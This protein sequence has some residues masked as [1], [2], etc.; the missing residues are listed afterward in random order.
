M[1]VFMGKVSREQA[2]EAIQT[3]MKNGYT[4]HYQEK[5][6]LMR[7]C[8]RDDRLR[9]RSLTM[10]ELSFLSILSTMKEV[11]GC[12]RMRKDVIDIVKKER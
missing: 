5:K 1:E 8:Y 12:E 3:G 2:I 6:G 9:S 7:I 4:L 10:T 11:K